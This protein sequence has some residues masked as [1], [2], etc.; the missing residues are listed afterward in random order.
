MVMLGVLTLGIHIGEARAEA[1]LDK[2]VVLTKVCPPP[3]QQTMWNC[4]AVE[5]REYRNVCLRRWKSAK[6]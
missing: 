1:R 5:A 2:P 4:D 3:K 6:P